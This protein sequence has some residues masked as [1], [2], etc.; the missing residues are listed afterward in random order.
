VPLLASFADITLRTVLKET[1]EPQLLLFVSFGFLLLYY[2]IGYFVT[3]KVVINNDTTQKQKLLELGTL[4]IIGSDLIIYAS[5]YQT[6]NTLSNLTWAGF[7]L[8]L[9]ALFYMLGKRSIKGF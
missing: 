6:G 5:L 4:S 9:I 7:Y 3:W 1:L 2:A 8:L